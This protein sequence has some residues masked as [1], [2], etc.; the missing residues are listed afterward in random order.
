MLMPITSNRLWFVLI[1][2]WCWSEGIVAKNASV[3]WW[4]MLSVFI[5]LGTIEVV[6]ISVFK[7]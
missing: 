3:K 5:V 6:V 4:H 2:V 1:F 7:N